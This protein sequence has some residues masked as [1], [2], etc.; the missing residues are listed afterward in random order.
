MEILIGNKYY[1]ILSYF[2][3]IELNECVVTEKTENSF[4]VKILNKVPYHVYSN[5]EG[6][7]KTKKEAC[8]SKQKELTEIYDDQMRILETLKEENEHS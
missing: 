2:N 7:F 3:R 1:R 6:W 8:E 5:L 4:L